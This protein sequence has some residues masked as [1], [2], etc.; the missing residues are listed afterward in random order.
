MQIKQL[1]IVSVLGNGCLV[2][3]ELN[4]A[5]LCQRVWKHLKIFQVDV[6]DFSGGPQK[7]LKILGLGWFIKIA[8]FPYKFWTGN[9][10][11]KKFRV[12]QNVLKTGFKSFYNFAVLLVFLLENAGMEG[13]VSGA[14]FSWVLIIW[15]TWHWQCVIDFLPSFWLVILL[16]ELDFV[17]FPA[18]VG[19]W[20]L[21]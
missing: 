9:W 7:E 18:K 5:N 21:F 12:M 17:E 20:I 10:Y 3:A 6:T 1:I 4:L 2:W 15:W 13:K 11:V 16:A 8:K 14:G 19:L